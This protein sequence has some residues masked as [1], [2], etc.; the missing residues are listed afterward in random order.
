MSERITAHLPKPPSSA[1]GE[2]LQ[3][4]LLPAPIDGMGLTDMQPAPRFAPQNMAQP[5]HGKESGVTS[6]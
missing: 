2:V 6:S 5:G 4:E 3:G 1:G